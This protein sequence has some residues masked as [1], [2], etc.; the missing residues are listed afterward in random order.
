MTYVFSPKNIV[1]QPEQEDTLYLSLST[2]DE[3]M[4]GTFKNLTENSMYL[5]SEAQTEGPVGEER[6]SGM[7]GLQDLERFNDAYRNFNIDMPQNTA[8]YNTNKFDGLDIK[9]PTQGALLPFNVGVQKINND[10]VV[11]GILSYNFLPGGPVMDMIDKTDQASDIDKL[12]FDIQRSVTHD[13][14]EYAR[15]DRALGFSTAFVGVRGWLEGRLSQNARGYWVPQAVGMGIK[16]EASGFFNSGINSP[17]FKANVTLGGELSTYAAIDAAPDTTGLGWAVNKNA[18]YFA[19][20]VQ[21]TTVSMNS[22]FT[23]GAGIDIYIARAICGV[24]GSLSASFDS[25]VRYRPYLQG[26][27]KIYNAMEE[28][29]EIGVPKSYTYSG[30]RMQVSGYVKAYAEAKFLWWKVRKEATLASF[31]KKWYDPD[32]YTNPIWVADHNASTTRSVLRSSVYQPLKLQAA[33][34]YTNIILRD[35]DTYAE[36]RYL[37]SGKDLAYYKINANDMTDAHLMFRN[38]GTFNSGQGEPIVT[39]DVSSTDSKGIIAYE[40]STATDDE[41]TD[42]A[43]APKHMGIKASVNN[44]MGWSTPVMLTGAQPANYTP[45]TAIDDNG[46]AAVAWKGGEFIASDY[47]DADKS[48]LVSGGLYMRRFD[49][50]NW[51]DAVMLTSTAKGHS[52]SDYALAMLDGKPYMLATFSKETDGDDGMEPYHTLA[53]IGYT[54][55][56]SPLLVEQTIE[57]SS[58]QLVN[59]GG[60]LFGAALVQEGGIS[61]DGDTTEVKTDVH[62]YNI[63]TDG[64]IVELGAMGLSNRNIADFRLMKSDKSMA[65]IWRE[66][67]QILN[68]TT[69]K[70][71]ITPSVYGALLRS[72]SSDEGHTVYFL[73]C[74][75][76]IAKAEGGLDIS[77][78]DAYLP[79]ESSMTGVVTLYNSETGGANVVES[80]NYFD[81]DFTIRHAG[82][83]T[84]VERGSDYGYYVVVFNE[85]KD[86]IDYVDLQLGE[87]SVTHTIPTCIYPGHDA[88]LTDEALYTTELENGVEPKVT[89]HFNESVL[90]TRTYAQAKAATLSVRSTNRRLTFRRTKAPRTNPRIQLQ[91]VDI[92]VRPLSV[93]VQGADDYYE[94]ATDTVITVPDDGKSEYTDS[95]PEKYTTV[96]V[97]VMNDSP[98]SLKSDYSTNISLCYDVKG[99]KPYEYAHS[100][101]IPASQFEAE[102]GSTVARILVG[103]V[104]EDVMLYAVAV[105]VDGE[106]NVIKDQYMVNNASAVRLQKNDLEFVPTGIEDVLIE[107][108]KTQ[109]TEPTF[110]V[111]VTDNGAMVRGLAEGQTLRVYDTMGRLLHLYHATA[112]GSEHFVRLGKHGVYLFSTGK[113]SVKMA[114]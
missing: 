106:G 41:I 109:D 84:K 94:A 114:F 72:S 110:D 102:G 95:I 99:Q 61:E 105:T 5:A 65:L 100:V 8:A 103:K 58:P 11:R 40:V 55:D 47:D 59:F 64:M 33:P 4:L 49:G 23:V 60:K 93:H 101:D 81:N 43:E 98:I 75:Q 1:V 83:D 111:T 31:D 112:K 18:K 28:K 22:T 74:P 29:P 113:Q 50:T 46:H 24:K 53:A 88:V 13:D 21:H 16:A 10:L 57:G 45:R 77:F 44:G 82:I 79:D 6:I 42:E 15:E 48:G 71:D 14:T 56:D 20:M 68:E 97:N 3:I 34:E 78:Y 66:S 39:A 27:R 104:P 86:V 73:S 108:E 36:P 63:S 32:N 91:T 7:A 12:F 96:L 30:S 70:L 89:P 67:T 38:G 9:L 90:K 17:F 51:G 62:L 92:N 37:F 69:G 2:G 25:E 19:D 76:L 85:G 107:K 35:I 54:T 26:A 80:T 87:E 52:A